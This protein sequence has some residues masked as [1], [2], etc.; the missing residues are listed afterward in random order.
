[1]TTTTTIDFRAT[2]PDEYRRASDVVSAA[3]MGT[4]V[5]DE[6]WD[7]R[8][9]LSWEEMPSFTAWDG[10]RCV[11]Q[12]GQFLVETVVPGGARLRTGA[13]SRVGVL[14]TYRRRGIATG[15]MHELIVDAER[16]GLAMMSLRAS[17][18]TIY[19]RFGFGLAGE[20]SGI[21][22]IAN[23]AAPIRGAATDGSMRLLRS[24]EIAEVIPDLYDRVACARPGAITRPPSW[25]RRIF[26]D[27]I[28]GTKASFV[29]VHTNADGIDD[30]FVHYETAWDDDHPDGPTGKGEVLD[31]F[32]ATPAAEL[33]LWQYLCEVDLIAR[34]K[35]YER[36]V[37]DLVR[38]ACT[39]MRAYRIRSVDDEQ[40]VRLVDLETALAA[41]RYAPVAGE[42]AVQ[43]T[44]PLF[45]RN[46]GTYT[47]SADGVRRADTDPDI[48][49]DIAGLS[50]AYLGGTSWFTLVATGRA[51][52]TEPTAVALADALFRAT[53][54]PFCGTFF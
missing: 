50:A 41:R 8:V 9:R 32:G 46:D 1:M 53:P 6:Q 27:A 34:W 11:G 13:V 51:R 26:K 24:D 36:P 47:V 54:G 30:G 49:T 18:A 3:L 37:D 23:R 52:T 22:L 5:T 38:T 21:E 10:D 20:Y 17:E 28:D 16:R 48:V 12:V 33:A 42:I 40:W 15:L 43:V 45:P 39:D 31:A 19:E 14:S 25:H 44:D 7:D 4:P 35:A 29:A 2:Q